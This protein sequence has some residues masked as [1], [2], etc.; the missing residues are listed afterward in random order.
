MFQETL[1]I[2]WDINPVTKERTTTF[3][4]PNNRMY[5]LYVVKPYDASVSIS[6]QIRLYEEAMKKTNQVP[7]DVIVSAISNN[8]LWEYGFE[9]IQYNEQ[10]DLNKCWH[11]NGSG[12]PVKMMSIIFNAAYSVLTETPGSVLTFFIEEESRRRLYKKFGERSNF[13]YQEID[14]SLFE[15]KVQPCVPEIFNSIKILWL[16]WATPNTSEMLKN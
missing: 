5:R 1:Q 13:E 12:K 11:V 3:L 16:L 4:G 15:S 2:D 7:K 9:D 10:G 8:N 14:Y 6:D